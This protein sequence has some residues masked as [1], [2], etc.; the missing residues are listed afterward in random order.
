MKKL[1]IT[2]LMMNS[3]FSF[4]GE[5]DLITTNSYS[6]E[7]G[8]R[9][10]LERMG[11]NVIEKDALTSSD[12]NKLILLQ[13]R[14]IPKDSG[15]WQQKLNI[16][17]VHSSGSYEKTRLLNY[18]AINKNSKRLKNCNQ[19]RSL[20]NKELDKLSHGRHSIQLSADG[21]R[22]GIFIVRE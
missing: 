7:G 14:H 10:K 9:E 15:P 19:T 3:F 21:K 1:L 20:L 12:A 11:F 8:V 2:M 16:G 6:L 22:N 5:C 18:I 4:A 17:L 13:V